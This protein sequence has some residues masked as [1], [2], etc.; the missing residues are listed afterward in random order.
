MQS[1]KKPTLCASRVRHYLM[2]LSANIQKLSKRV[3]RSSNGSRP[4]ECV[5]E[6]LVGLA[7]MFTDVGDDAAHNPYWLSG[8]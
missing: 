3:K 8:H 2:A 7:T 4:F 5:R 1:Y 6:I